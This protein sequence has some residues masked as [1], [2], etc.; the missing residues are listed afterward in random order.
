MS[1]MTLDTTTVR[2]WKRYPQYRA[3]E[4]EWL[5]DV[6]KQWTSMKIKRL[7][8]VKR[9]ASPR[10]IDDPIYFD[11]NG[12]YAWVR[13]S[14]VTASEKYLRTTEEKLSQLGNSKSVRLE[15]G[16]LFLSIAASIGKPIITKIKCCI[17]DG[18]VYFVG[19]KQDPEYWYYL[20]KS[21]QLFCGLGKMGTRN[22][23]AF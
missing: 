16:R 19:L 3:T 6:P 4:V 17:H 22:A 5:G 9:G 18:F 12:E 2:R 1:I 10:P 13:I 8:Q 11:E 21:E 15:P 23:S 7:C 14:D 20:F